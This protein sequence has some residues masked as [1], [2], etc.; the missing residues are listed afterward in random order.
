MEPTYQ[1]IIFTDQVKID[2]CM[3][4]LSAQAEFQGVTLILAR[5][6]KHTTENKWFYFREDCEDNAN[7]HLVNIQQ[8]IQDS[9]D[10]GDAVEEIKTMQEMIDEGY[11][12]SENFTP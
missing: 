10:S 5:I 1:L 9:L 4:T 2:S 6:N 7:G 11:L 12:L 8:T 3:V